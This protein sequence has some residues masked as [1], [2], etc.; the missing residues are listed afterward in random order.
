M[1]KHI[2]DNKLDNAE[3]DVVHIWDDLS[4]F[5]GGDIEVLYPCN[6]VDGYKIY[7]RLYEEWENAQAEMHKYVDKP[8]WLESMEESY[9]ESK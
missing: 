6:E 7:A 3:M 9:N 1:E 2:R 4:W 5:I 8:A